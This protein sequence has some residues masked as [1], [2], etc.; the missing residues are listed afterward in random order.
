MKETTMFRKSVLTA[1]LVA[2][3]VT[4]VS[5][6]M[7]VSAIA[8]V[9]AK[10][11]AAITYGTGSLANVSIVDRNTGQTLPV[12]RFR[13]EYWVA[14]TP[15]AKYSVAVTNNTGERVMA[16]ISVDG[17]NVL[18]GDT[19]RVDQAGYVFA[20]NQRYEIA[21]WRKSDR[22]IAAFQFVA[23]PRSYAERTGRPE[24]VGVIGVALFRERYEAPAWAPYSHE[25]QPG[26]GNER[27]RYKRGEA[28]DA[29]GAA[30]AANAPAPSSAPSLKS[31]GR[32]TE[33]EAAQARVEP[34]LGT[35]HG[36]REW[37]AVSHTE[38]QRAQSAPN[39]TIRIRYDSTENLI[40]M[41]VIRQPFYGYRND[42]A[43]NP[44]P[45]SYVQRN[46]VPDP[47]RHRY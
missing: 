11:A 41:G 3:A 45:E 13:G 5:A 47:P 10:P 24:N 34:K 35:G 22:E 20:S 30:E 46:Y 9:W 6:P 2:T 21:G 12:Y 37:S 4:A 25:Q 27:Y 44:F 42:R 14:G 32:V 39:E 23:S 43:P 19:A 29:A 18:N 31:Y 36:A 33:S 38:F 8:P 40:A 15:G 28:S 26:Y 16:V 1:A 7:S 17:V